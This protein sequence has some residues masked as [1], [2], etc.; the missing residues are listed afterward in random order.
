MNTSFVFTSIGKLLQLLG[1]ILIIPALISYSEVLPKTLLEAL[2]T[3]SLSGFLFAIPTSLIFGTA[4]SLI[5]KRP[6][7]GNA[8]KEGFTIVTFGW[9]ILTFFGAIPLLNYFLLTSIEPITLKLF[10][11]HFT[12]SYFEI[13]SGFTTTGSTILTDIESLPRGLLFWRSLTHWLGGMGIVTLVLAIFPAS[14]I[15]TYQM[16][17]GEVPGPTAEKLGPKLQQTAKILWGVYALLTLLETGLLMIGGM[18]L[19]DSLC[20]SFGTLATGGFSTQNGSIAD[21]NSPYFDWII[22][23]FMYLAGMNFI[24]HFQ[25]IFKRNFS[26][27]KTNS[28]FKF[29]TKTLLI[30]IIFSTFFLLFKGVA[31]PD[32]IQSSFRSTPLT[33]VQLVQTISEESSKVSTFF[34]SLRYSAFQ[35]LAITTTTGFATADFDIWPNAIKIMLVLLMFFGGSSGSTGGGIKMLRIQ[36]VL[37]TVIREIRRMVQP[38]R[39]ES[40]KIGDA[41]IEEKQVANILGFFMLFMISFVVLSF[42]MSFYIHDFTTATTSVVATLCNIGPGLSGVGATENFNWIPTGGKWFLTAA[43]LLGRLELY[44]VIIAFAPSSWKK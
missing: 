15:T 31:E 16:F 40:V 6:L 3:P 14:G 18:P 7:K 42:I 27:L 4:L 38:R 24:L 22:T 26:V 12:N 37:K 19:F 20:H 11:H 5:R 35:V 1:M 8:I 17:R 21:Y 43:M 23:A 2:L 33:E 41:P 9:I 44:T 25:I 30:A 28:E 39:I 13:M 29:Y 34:G 10:T 36:V 32:V